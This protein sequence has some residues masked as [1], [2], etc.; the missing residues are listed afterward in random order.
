[1][2][3]VTSNT[4]EILKKGLLLIGHTAFDYRMRCFSIYL[5]ELK[6]WSKAYNLT[7]IRSDEDIVIKHFLDS[8]LYLKAIPRGS[9]RVADVGSGAGFPGIPLKIVRPELE[10]FLI[11]PSGKKAAFL[12]H[13]ARRLQIDKIEII[14]KRVEEIQVS[15][16]LKAAVDIVLTRALF[17]IKE[18][19][20]RAA[21]IV[22]PTGIFML[23]KGPKVTEELQKAEDLE[24]E[25]LKIP[26]P[27]TDII[28]YIVIVKGKRTAAG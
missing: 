3:M 12:R 7:C 8:L 26:L 19:V 23:S 15:Q 17:T 11:E 14:E 9:L 6:K 16:E 21:H 5:S 4:A 1:M 22:K 2:D 25:L 24:F 28:R 27:H 20:R 13:I 10:M 18:F